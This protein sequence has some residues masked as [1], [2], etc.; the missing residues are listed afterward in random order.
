MTL[1]GTASVDDSSYVQFIFDNADYNIRTLDGYGTFHAMGG[2]QS[3]TPASSLHAEPL[4]PRDLSAGVLSNV[5][6]LGNIQMIWYKQ[7]AEVG[8]SR[9]IVEDVSTACLQ[10]EPESAQITRLLDV[11]WAVVL[12]SNL[13]STNKPGWSG[14]ME[15]GHR[16]LAFDKSA[17]VPLPFINYD[18]T[19]LSTIYTALVY[20]AKESERLKQDKVFVT[21]DQPLCCKA[22]D[23][24]FA[25]TPDSRLSRVEVRLGGFHLLMSFL[26]A[27][28]MIMGGSGLEELWNT[29]YAKNSVIHMISGRQ[30]SRAL[31]AHFLTQQ[32]L[33]H[34]LFQ[35]CPERQEIMYNVEDTFS[36][37]IEG[38]LLPEDVGECRDV[39]TVFTVLHD[40]IAELSSQNRTANL[41]VQYYELVEIVRMYIRAE[42]SGDWNLHLY[43]VQSMLPYFHAAGHLNYAK[44]AHVYLQRMLKLRDTMSPTDLENFVGKSY[45]TIRRT[46]KFWSG[47]WSDMIIEQYLMRAM[48]S[49]GGLTHGRGFTSSTI[50]KWIKAMP[51]TTKVVD[52]IETLSGVS[53]AT[54][55]QHVELRESRNRRDAADA[56]KILQWLQ[57]HNPFQRE[58][59]LLVS[60]NNGL[61]A[62]PTVNCD[63]AKEVGLRAMNAIVGKPFNEV[64]LKRKDV[65]VTLA[66][67]QKGIRI[68]EELI[69]VNPTQ[70]FHRMVCVIR[71]DEELAAN[72][73][74]ELAA[75][76]PALF[77]DCCMRKGS[78]KAA[79]IP[80]L[81]S[82]CKPASSLPNNIGNV[83]YIIDG[84]YLLHKCIW[85]RNER[86]QEIVNKYVSYVT[87][88]YGSTD[89]TVVFD[90][91]SLP[92][93]KDCEHARRGESSEVIVNENTYA[94]LTPDVF[95][96]NSK[97]KTRLIT[98][99]TK[100][101]TTAGI[102]VV[103]AETD[104]DTLIVSTAIT[105]SK[106]G[107]TSVLVGEDTDLL[108]L[109]IAHAERDI[110]M[111]IPSKGK[112]TQKVY[113]SKS[114]QD[115]L[116]VMKQYLLFIHAVTG[117]DTTSALHGK[118]KSMAF[119]K[120]KRDEEL[121][122]KVTVFNDSSSSSEDIAEA[123]EAFLCVLYGGKWTDKLNT[124]RH[125]LYV[126]TVAKQR[127]S[128]N[129]KLASLPPTSD[130]ARQHSFRVFLQV[131]EWRNV[132]LKPSEWG[133]KIINGQF[134]PIPALQEPAP[135]HILCLLACNC[136]KGCDRRSCE[137]RRNG[138]KCSNMCGYCSGYGCSNRLTPI[139]EDEIDAEHE[140]ND[141]EHL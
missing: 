98:I 46:D 57:L 113:S 36:D 70:L 129:F 13:T 20:V 69:E 119:D 95:F 88:H 137:C 90:G 96:S 94:A 131:Q 37:I 92:S 91:Y 24:L 121:Q 136:K 22:F 76:P 139:E 19:N 2:V 17:L 45:F 111:L 53:S 51:A 35:T 14:F 38:Q 44:T 106:H 87:D 83:A 140:T 74:F 40:K 77:K 141:F 84:G 27:I 26:G 23:I 134:T 112:R 21:F 1:N 122:R 39:Q 71:S 42:R 116:G 56:L 108:V 4:V 7:P 47:T 16:H 73:H 3:V 127:I 25:A 12:K 125:K 79:L 104:A 72:L 52:A 10:L 89:V 100:H 41:W 128:G 124:M 55:E 67:A 118:G 75:W 48:K 117:C 101:L 133:W 63:S 54:T 78:G 130:A 15:V 97:N 123:G 8:L 11:L 102:N 28:G 135:Q 9:V 6:G 105:M 50:A 85:Q 99:L 68:R 132:K 80:V 107:K 59:T 62:P 138:L 115:S 29:I 33:T 30:Y 65:V 43:C 60:V 32:A 120:L 34:L 49:T 64:H 110:Y 109:L 61:V 126:K 5:G 18:P 103:Q 31:R 81:E 82:Y 114:L 66:T 58:S 86:Y 93:T